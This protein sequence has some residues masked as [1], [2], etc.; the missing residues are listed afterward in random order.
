M[1]QTKGINP[2]PSGVTSPQQR[3]YLLLCYMTDGLTTSQ[4]KEA[5][6]SPSRGLLAVEARLQLW[7]RLHEDILVVPSAYRGRTDLWSMRRRAWSD[8]ATT[9]GTSTGIQLFLDEISSALVKVINIALLYNP[10][11]TFVKL[12]VHIGEQMNKTIKTHQGQI[13]KQAW[14]SATSGS[15]V[16]IVGEIKISEWEWLIVPLVIACRQAVSAAVRAQFKEVADSVSEKKLMFDKIDS[17][18]AYY[19]VGVVWRTALKA[20]VSSER[21]QKSIRLLF[22]TKKQAE[23]E[24]L[25]TREVDSK[26]VTY[27]HSQ[28]IT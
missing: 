1:I 25:P 24:G 14:N 18:K 7:E 22:I 20:F 2:S 5:L 16:E 19:C 28:P 12:K 11:K 4:P 15:Q 3:S 21:I 6:I 27:T 8:V 9:L 13:F 23:I 26:Y 10:R 17:Q